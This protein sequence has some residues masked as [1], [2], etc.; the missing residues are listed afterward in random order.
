MFY[1]IR[2]FLIPAVCIMFLSACAT[3][4]TDFEQPS[5]S[6]TSFKSKPSNSVS[7]EFEI[8]LHITN[9]NRDSLEL[10][11]V[12]YTINLNDN[13]VISGVANDLPTIEPYGEADVT[14]YATADLFGGFQLL[15]GLMNTKNGQI[16]YEFNAK[17]DAG[18]FKP[19][20]RVS[21][22]GVL[23]ENMGR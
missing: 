18:L 22:K 8:V 12:S 23:T 15:T 7:P 4:P 19:L 10:E 6:V 17:L 14:L 5:V 16:E 20:I 21:K 9:P 13:K 1:L 11:G 3:T 2:L